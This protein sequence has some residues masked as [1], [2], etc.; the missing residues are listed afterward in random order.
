M[1][2]QPPLEINPQSGLLVTALK[3]DCSGV[4]ACDCGGCLNL[5]S[6]WSLNTRFDI[7]M[8]EHHFCGFFNYC[9]SGSTFMLTFSKINVNGMVYNKKNA[10]N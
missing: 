9:N 3:P 1:G 10:A 5:I 7:V 4:V 6:E 8:E 2:V